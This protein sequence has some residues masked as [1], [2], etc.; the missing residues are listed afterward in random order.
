MKDYVLFPTNSTPIEKI[1]TKAKNLIKLAT[2]PNCQVPMF[3]VVTTDAHK[4]ILHNSGYKTP[5]LFTQNNFRLPTGLDKQLRQLLKEKFNKKLVIRS[6][7]T[8][9]DTPFLTFAGQYASFLGIR[10]HKKTVEAIRMCYNSLLS[11]NAKVYSE[12]THNQITNQ[13]MAIV[14]QKM[15]KVDIS[16]VMFTA[17]PVFGKKEKIVI[18][19]TSGLGDNL[20]SGN[21]IPTFKEVG[22][23]KVQ[24]NV[25]LEKLRQVAFCVEKIFGSP[26][27]VEWGYCRAKDEIYLFQSRPIM[28]PTTKKYSLLISRDYKLLFSGR[29]ASS[30]IVKGRL[31]IIS[32]KDNLKKVRNGD[33][34]LAKQ[35]IG[36][37]F[38]APL[39][40]AGGLIFG[41]GVL[42]HF[43]VITRELAIPCLGYI[44][45][46][47]DLENLEAKEV[48]LDTRKKFGNVYLK[49]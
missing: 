22:K 8:S 31:R 6:S 43:G 1:G 44:R 37:E 5:V 26:Q 38:I 28:F 10:G 15:A 27:D 35:K 48:L 42:S 21:T 11:E 4:Y 40:F 7:A 49:I 30:G 47:R 19:N 34:L 2:V 25:L 9:E 32:N 33:I 14:I 46:T 16:G 24:S 45:F 17:D 20:T 13:F 3:F 41:G 36:K 23:L 18:E 39:R 29:T 12:L